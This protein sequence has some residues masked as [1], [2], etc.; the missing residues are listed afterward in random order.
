M[1]HGINRRQFLKGS[2]AAVAAM[3]AGG[4]LAQPSQKSPGAVPAAPSDKD[5]WSWS[6]QRTAMSIKT[7]AITSLQATESCLQRIAEVNPRVNALNYVNVESALQMARQADQQRAQGARIGPLHGVPLAIKDNTNE[8]GRPMTNGIVA[9]KD[10]IAA[11]DAPQV[12][13]LRKAG[14]VFVGR[15]NTPSF[16]FRWDSENDLH[17]VTYNPWNRLRTPGGSSGGAACAVQS[18]PA[19]SPSHMATISAAPSGI[20]RIVA[21]W[22]ACAPHRA[23]CRTC[24]AP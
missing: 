10:N 6:A 19:W 5:I 3:S 22:S 14:A 13:M 20:P 18:R 24:S 7:G 16:S 2:V 17:G 9:L 23:V 12:A 11:Q 15:S 4:S 8:R 21:A 1:K